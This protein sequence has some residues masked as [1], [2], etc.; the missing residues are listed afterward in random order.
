M[1]FCE[2][3]SSLVKFTLK[4]GEKLLGSLGLEIAVDYLNQSL[5][6]GQVGRIFF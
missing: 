3:L 4:D 2:A 1:F 6:N 5:V